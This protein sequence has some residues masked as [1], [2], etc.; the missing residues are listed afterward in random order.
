MKKIYRRLNIWNIFRYIFKYTNVYIFKYSSEIKTHINVIK[1]I[2]EC[3]SSKINI[4]CHQW[5]FLHSSCSYKINEELRKIYMRVYIRYLEDGETLCK[6]DLIFYYDFK[7]NLKHT[8]IFK[9]NQI[10]MSKF[11]RSSIYEHYYDDIFYS[12]GFLYRIARLAKSEEY[13]ELCTN[14]SK[15]DEEEEVFYHYKTDS[16]FM[17]FKYIIYSVY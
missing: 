17:R 10:V 15:N 7:G 8:G 16:S 4:T 11:G 3:I 5:A 1:D 9:D 14:F 13:M 6:N 12:Y 2:E